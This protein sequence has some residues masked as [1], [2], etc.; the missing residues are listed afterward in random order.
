MWCSECK[1]YWISKKKQMQQTRVGIY[2]IF[3]SF[4]NFL[5]IVFFCCCC[6]FYIHCYILSNVANII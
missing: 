4:F 1:K 6:F 2:F 3:I 5:F